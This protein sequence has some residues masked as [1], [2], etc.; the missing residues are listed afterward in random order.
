[1]KIIILV[2]SLLTLTFQ[3]EL[4]N[5]EYSVELRK[6]YKWTDESVIS[7]KEAKDFLIKILTKDEEYD[8]T[9]VLRGPPGEPVSID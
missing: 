2:L 7:K 8:D 5:Q 1:M 3:N 6:R 4:L 9:I